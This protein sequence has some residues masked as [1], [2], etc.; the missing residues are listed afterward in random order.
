MTSTAPA[1]G[2]LPRPPFTRYR[3]GLGLLLIRAFAL[4]EG[5]GGQIE[6]I[7]GEAQPPG[8]RAIVPWAPIA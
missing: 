7:G 4:V 3:G 2:S 6:T 1:D 8:L 5:V